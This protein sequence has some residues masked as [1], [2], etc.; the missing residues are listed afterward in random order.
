MVQGPMLLMILILGIVLIILMISKF[1]IHPFISLLLVAYGI[2]LAARMP[3]GDI[4]KTVGDGF[5][6]LLG[7]IGIVI[8]LGTI[9]GTILEKSGGA[10]KM[11]DVVI[12]IVGKKRP[13]LAMAIIGYIVSIPV[14]CDSGFV[15]LNSL[16]KSLQKRTKASSI[17]MT[18]ALATG[19]YATHTLVPPT[20]GPIA[21]AANLGMEKN[22]LLIIIFGLIIAIPAMLAG[23]LYARW[24]GK[25]LETPEDI[26]ESIESYEDLLKK[27]GRLPSAWMSFAPIVVPILLMA[28][29]S[30][31][32][33]PGDPFGAGTVKAVLTFL[34][35]PV[36]ALFIGFFFSL[37]LLPKLNE[38]TLTDWVSESLKSAAIILLVTGAG[39]ALGAVLKATKIGDY[40]GQSLSGW[41]L[42]IFLPFIVAAALKTAQGSSTVALVTTSSLLAPLL[43]ALG[44]QSDIARTLVVMAVG[45]GAM[46]VSHANDSFFWVVSQFGNMKVND[47]YKAQTIA[48]LIQGI[49]TIAFIAVLSWLLI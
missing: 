38:E 37:L 17:A 43:P 19:L 30:I 35:T 46:T 2:A 15:I 24:I 18:V 41:N 47:A 12:R 3:L 23:Y 31:A 34:G 49:V 42:G 5:G 1:K 40:L 16:R 22:L 27:Y 20:P 10:L 44:F 25:R 48:T 45:A 29:G 26:E 21:A 14:F 36:N 9:I 6:S 7:G 39:G 8:V 13:T 11:A 28:L 32:K 4:S 33:F